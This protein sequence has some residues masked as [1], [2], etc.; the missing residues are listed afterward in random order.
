MAPEETR[1]SARL[2]LSA[3]L[4]ELERTIGKTVSHA[5]SVETRVPAINGFL[6]R[7]CGPVR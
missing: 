7:V 5:V 1:R 4:A 6:D 3:R 2:V